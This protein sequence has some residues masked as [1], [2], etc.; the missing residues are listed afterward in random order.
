MKKIVILGS[1][2]HIGTQ[3]LE[4]IRAYPKDFKVVGLS[5]NSNK[6][7]LEEQVKEFKPEEISIGGNN[8]EK[9][10]CILEADLVLVAV[11]GLAGLKPT[12]AA[13]KAKKKI[14]LATKEVLVLAGELVMSEAKKNKVDI[15][16]VDSEH[17]AIFQSLKSGE[18][19]EV[20][21]IILTMGK[22]RFAL[23]SQ[24]ELDSI[25][26]KD[27]YKNPTWIMGQKITIDSA[28]CLNKS[29]E[30]IEAK[31]LFGLPS[32]KIDIIVHPE[33][34]CHSLVEFKDGS[35]VGE[36]GS[37]DMK[38]YIQYA[39]FYPKR[40]EAKTTNKINLFNKRIT[41]EPPSYKKFPGL[42]LGFQAL[43]A[44]GTMPA[45]MHGADDVAVEAFIKNKI[46]FTEITSVIEKTMSR[47]KPIKTPDLEQI[48]D[49]NKWGKIYAGKIICPIY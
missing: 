10:A 48:L 40:V 31:W 5:A 33:Y 18:I 1:T 49:A 45:V 39:L 30:V 35:I 6:K 36:F 41:F 21:K 28:T 37:Q 16:P 32:K 7:L 20:K 23:M 4:V 29:F 19:S 42:K 11:V 46:K 22:G 17:S 44:G 38:R 47:Y 2:G 25:T 3:A 15:I 14:A 26:L 34:L 24:K 8:L 43:E 9:I 12:L 13:I 27:I